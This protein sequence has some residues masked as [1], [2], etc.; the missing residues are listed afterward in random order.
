MKT[1]ILLATSLFF[2]WA[3]A[4]QAHNGTLNGQL[5]EKKTGLELYGAYVRL[6]PIG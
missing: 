5:L 2:L 3:I 4:L 6:E 1:K